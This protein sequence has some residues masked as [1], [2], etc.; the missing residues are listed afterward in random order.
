MTKR[1]RTQPE[2]PKPHEPVHIE[3]ETFREI[4]S[5]EIGNMT[6]AGPSCFNGVVRFR[7]CRVRIDEIDEPKEVLAARIQA[8]WDHTDNHH[9]WDPLRR[10][11]AEIGYTL[12]GQHGSKRVQK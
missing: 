6:S 11:A 10:A 3:F 7:R 9:H 5:H 1:K 4:G 12:V 2:A 8:L